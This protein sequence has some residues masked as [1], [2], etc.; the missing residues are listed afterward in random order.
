MEQAFQPKLVPGKRG[1]KELL[2]NMIS[3]ILLILFQHKY[4][5][6]NSEEAVAK[7]IA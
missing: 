2:L 1:E 5:F 7:I 3:L 6:N 4:Q